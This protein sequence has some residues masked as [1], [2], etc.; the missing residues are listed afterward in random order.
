MAQRPFII[1]PSPLSIATPKD[2]RRLQ[3]P[4][5]SFPSAERQKERLTPKIEALEAES[6]AEFHT[7]L[8]GIMPEQV[9]VLE[10]V[11]TIAEFRNAVKDVTG[12]EWLGE[13]DEEF[14][15]DADFQEEGK[16]KPLKGKLFLVLARESAMTTLLA[17]WK[18]WKKNPSLP[19]ERGSARFKTLFEQLY[20]IRHWDI[21]DRIDET[22]LREDWQ[23]RLERGDDV[24]RFEA[25]LWYRENQD[26]SQP[27]ERFQE[28]LAR[29][30]GRIINQCILPQIAY[31][32]VLAEAPVR[33]IE[34][35]FADGDVSFLHCEQVMF[36]RPAGQAISRLSDEDPISDD[37]PALPAPPSSPISVLDPVVALLDGLP[38]QNHNQLQGHLIVDDPDDWATLY[39]AQYRQHGTAMASL[40]LHGELDAEEPVLSRPIYTRPVMQPGPPDFNNQRWESIPDDMLSVDLIH[41]AVQRIFRGE[42][43]DDPVAPSI[44]IINFSIGDSNRPFR[45]YMSSWARLFDWIALEYNVL[46]FVSAGNHTKDIQLPLSQSAF[47]ALTPEQRDAQILQSLCKEASERRLLSP[48]EAINVLTIGALH[49]DQSTIERPDQRVDVLSA[50]LPSPV[51]S[52]GMGF[53]R[54]IKPDIFLP[55][56]K[57]LYEPQLTTNSNSPV[58]FRQRDVY[59]RAPG[60]KVATPGRAGELNATRWICGTS[61]ATALATRTAAR[62]YENLQNLRTEPGGEALEEKYMPVLMK[63]L[64]VHGAD[65]GNNLAVVKEALANE[66]GAAP[67]R[68]QATRFLGYGDV[69]VERVLSCTDWRATIIGCGSLTAGQSQLYRVKLPAS[70]SGMRAWRRLTITLAWFSPINVQHRK[71]RR[72]ALWFDPQGEPLMVDRAEADW[73]AVKRG[74]VQ[75]EVLVGEKATSFAE[76]DALEV[77][78]NCR[79]NAGELTNAVPY[80]LAVSLEVEDSQQISLYNEIQEGLRPLI[81]IKS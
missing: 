49:A 39:P 1:F 3:P 16:D 15:Q 56:G 2:N 69:D 63:A 10:T 46:I 37:S 65:W 23:Q 22:G 59:P 36:F 34:P 77:R 80:A 29:S 18:R 47:N 32:G 27:Y 21:S 26:V 75:H 64:I 81:P 5:Y 68:E 76:N 57:Q 28:S 38:L 53:Q 52:L 13:S 50:G 14:L 42:N 48:A 9:L 12:M 19:F 61:N 11:G 73:N 25:E 31:H 7:E 58:T 4:Q 71:Y 67:A 8:S 33:N 62:L 17:W 24:V 44:R 78:V 51:T 40:I 20:D 43:G 70:L 55:G 60:Q 30:G 6:K 41:R 54:S 66:W 72:A 45:Y 35:L 74:T 79:A